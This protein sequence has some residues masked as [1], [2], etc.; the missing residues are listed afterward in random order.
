MSFINYQDPVPISDE[1]AK[2][3]DRIR[4]CTFV[5]T[6]GIRKGRQCKGR[7]SGYIGT[8]NY[9]QEHYMIVKKQEDDKKEVKQLQISL[10]SENSEQ[11]SVEK[12]IIH[13]KI[14]EYADVTGKKGYVHIEQ[15]HRFVFDRIRAKVFLVEEI[16]DEEKKICQFN[17]LNE[18][19][20][21]ILSDAG[22]PWSV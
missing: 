22:I 8:E 17:Y 13:P 11:M 7:I 1:L 3:M 5:I 20:C 14:S 21:K 9:C 6:K 19:H 15:G 10:N 4:W 16:I 18:N 12:R 2:F